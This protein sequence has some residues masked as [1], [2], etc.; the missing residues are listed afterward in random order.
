[1]AKSLPALKRPCPLHQG[2]VRRRNTPAA[3][4]AVDRREP[5]LHNIA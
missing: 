4:A 3:G 5:V 2:L 1:M